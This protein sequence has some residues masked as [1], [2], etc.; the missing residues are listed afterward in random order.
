MKNVPTLNQIKMRQKAATATA[1]LLALAFAI[2]VAVAVARES[3]CVESAGKTISIAPNCFSHADDINNIKI[4]K[5][6]E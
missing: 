5:H 4:E 1:T 6:N 2:A 3:V